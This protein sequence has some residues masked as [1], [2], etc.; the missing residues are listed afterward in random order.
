MD[1]NASELKL[2][3]IRVQGGSGSAGRCDALTLDL[4]SDN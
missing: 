3:G 2:A 1:A 4:K